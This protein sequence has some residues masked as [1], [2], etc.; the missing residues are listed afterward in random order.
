MVLCGV[1][2]R[3]IAFILF[4]FLSTACATPQ[5][6]ADFSV[7]ALVADAPAYVAARYRGRAL[8]SA[9]IADLTAAGFHCQHSATASEC[10]R[11]QHAFAA[12]FDVVSV[13]IFAGAPA[14]AEKNR[15]CLGAQE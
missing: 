6:R 12:C 13:R 2:G 15:R 11:S 10:G 5:P 4:A 1:T 7:D 8:P 14:Q 3:P 9:L